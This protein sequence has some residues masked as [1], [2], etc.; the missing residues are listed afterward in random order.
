M[1]LSML[2]GWA[3][4]GCCEGATHPEE[5]PSLPSFAAAALRASAE[6]VI[7]T[8]S[9]GGIAIQQQSSAQAASPSACFRQIVAT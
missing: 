2:L 7:A 8:A 6:G 4:C 3:G 1:D 9:P 5:R